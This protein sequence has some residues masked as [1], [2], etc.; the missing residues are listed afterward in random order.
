MPPE[1]AAL[2]RRGGALWE[3]HAAEINGWIVKEGAVAP[4][5]RGVG[6]PGGERN[7]WGW[8]AFGVAGV[9]LGGLAV[10]LRSEV[11]RVHPVGEQPG[12]QQ[13]HDNHFTLTLPIS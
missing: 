2:L 9:A 12:A 7:G 10:R 11:L 5:S 4:S 8:L 6:R 13:H 3:E 1:R